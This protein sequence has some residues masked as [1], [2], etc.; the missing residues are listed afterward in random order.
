MLKYWECHPRSSH[1]EAAPHT[2]HNGGASEW[3]GEVVQS[4]AT[5]VIHLSGGDA[6]WLLQQL[7]K[8]DEWQSR[9]RE[10]AHLGWPVVHLQVDVG[11]EVCAPRSIE[12]MVPDTLQVGWQHGGLS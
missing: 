12:M 5:G 9:L 7:N 10:V 4:P 1:R 8:T 3:V 6:A 11:V 2:I